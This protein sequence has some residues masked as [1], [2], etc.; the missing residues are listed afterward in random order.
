MYQLEKEKLLDLSQ[1]KLEIPTHKKNYILNCHKISYADGVL[2][3][4]IPYTELLVT[5]DAKQSVRKGIKDLEEKLDITII[6]ISSQ[7]LTTELGNKLAGHSK[8]FA[9]IEKNKELLYQNL[10]KDNPQ[11]I[12]LFF[13]NE[14]VESP[15]VHA[16][17]LLIESLRHMT[18]EF[19]IIAIN[20]ETN[21]TTFEANDNYILTVAVTNKHN[22][23]HDSEIILSVSV[24]KYSDGMVGNFVDF[25]GY[26]KDAIKE[27]LIKTIKKELALETSVTNAIV[28]DIYKNSKLSNISDLVIKMQPTVLIVLTEGCLD[29]LSFSFEV[30]FPKSN[31]STSEHCSNFQVTMD[32]I[33]ANELSFSNLLSLL[34]ENIQ[35]EQEWIDTIVKSEELIG[36][37]VNSKEADMKASAKYKQNEE[38]SKNLIDEITTDLSLLKGNYTQ[39][40]EIN[41]DLIDSKAFNIEFVYNTEKLKDVA[42]NIIYHTERDEISIAI[43]NNPKFT[44]YELVVD[45]YFDFSQTR[46]FEIKHILASVVNE[47]EPYL[48]AIIAQHKN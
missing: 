16:Y 12:N 45:A 33:D 42:I 23:S 2:C 22:P 18:Y 32:V 15:L 29:M 28:T 20:V 4:E 3:V 39:C 14:I 37:I 48:P 41:K 7:I 43:K 38:Q 17:P 46:F 1:T 8:S 11:E 40:E 36:I 19:K 25:I 13:V 24:K 31:Y 21:I 47:L 27:K 35:I 26:A 10:G 9:E 30:T 34:E 5:E 6:P 44:I